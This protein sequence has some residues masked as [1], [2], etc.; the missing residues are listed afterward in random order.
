M[1]LGYYEL[2]DASDACCVDCALLYSQGVLARRAA[3]FL[4]YR[5]NAGDALIRRGI[6][7]L[8]DGYEVGPAWVKDND[9]VAKRIANFDKRHGGKP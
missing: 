5:Y 4:G 7:L 6:K 3:T 8:A 2:A 9:Y 1:T